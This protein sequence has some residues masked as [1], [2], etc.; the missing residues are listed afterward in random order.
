MSDADG[1][2]L[3]AA[4]GLCCEGWVDPDTRF[5]A[6][7]VAR[8]ASRVAVIDIRGC[9]GMAQPCVFHRDGGCAVYDERPEACREFSCGTLIRM[10]AGA[11]SAELALANITAV[12]RAAEAT[13]DAMATSGWTREG[14]AAPDAARRLA[15][16]A[17]ADA[18]DAPFRRR[19]AQAL[20]ADVE[21][22]ALLKRHV[23][24]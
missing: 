20:M 7:E 8:F 12:R 3:C 6:D 21:F 16:A 15:Q 18:A 17:R 4:C 13:A 22:A 1:A 2:A 10:Q 24:L 5:T 19:Y 11:I 9:P 23:L 14:E